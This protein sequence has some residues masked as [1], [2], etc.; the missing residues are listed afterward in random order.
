MSA[1]RNNVNKSMFLSTATCGYNAC[2]VLVPQLEH[3]NGTERRWT[4][5][6]IWIAYLKLHSVLIA[7][8]ASASTKCSSILLLLDYVLLVSAIGIQ[9]D[10]NLNRNTGWKSLFHEN[11]ISGVTLLTSPAPTLSVSIAMFETSLK[12]RSPISLIF[13]SAVM[14]D[15]GST[16]MVNIGRIIRM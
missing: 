13:S 6:V 10:F 9:R 11:M 15:N 8:I 3:F 2:I 16:W 5:T 4:L 14:I 1:L 7:F 12:A